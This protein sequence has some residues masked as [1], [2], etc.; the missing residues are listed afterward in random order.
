[1]NYGPASLRN[2]GIVASMKEQGYD[3]RDRGDVEVRDV[4]NDPTQCNVN[5]PLTIGADMKRTSEKVYSVM[6]EN[7]HSLCLNL[8]GDHTVAIGTIHGHLKAE[9]D[10]VVVWVDAH[11]D[12]NPP[13]ASESGNIHG[14]PLS[15]L[16]HEMAPYMPQVPGFEWIQP[17]LHAK[18]LAYIGIRDLDPAEKKVLKDLGIMH[19]DMQKVDQLGIHQCMV[20]VIN[21]LNPTLDKPFHLSFDID[22]LDPTH[23]PSTGTPVPGGLTLREGV[24]IA[25]ALQKT[26]KLRAFDLVEVNPKLG[27]E[28][29][30]KVTVKTACDLVK[31]SLGGRAMHN[32]APDYEIPL[33]S[34]A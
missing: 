16:V 12:I 20:S 10:A 9:P 14:M 25:E 29:D 32:L 6:S 21:A 26:G 8:G 7:K 22:G 1:M 4:P 24:Y 30:V 33:P 18:N 5:H 31:L 2:N 11:A 27:S 34:H 28:A 19:F 17:C 3:V 15:F 13:P 23:A